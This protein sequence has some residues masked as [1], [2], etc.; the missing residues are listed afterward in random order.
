[1]TG[2][3][4]ET[5]G[6]DRRRALGSPSAR[7][8]L[9]TIFGNNVLPRGEVWTGTVVGVLAT[10]GIEEK[11]ARQALA[12][13]A[14]D[15]WLASTR[16]GRRVRWSFTA[17][18]RELFTRGA[19]RIFSFG[20]EAPSWDG[21]WLV[22]FTSVP[23]TRRELRHRLRTRLAWAGFGSPAPGVWLSPDPN[24]EVEAKEVLAELGLDDT[25]S[26]FVAQYGTIGEPRQLVTAAWD[27]AG[28]E[29]SYEAFRAQ[30]AGAQ[31][32]RDE[33]TFVAHTR[34]VD[35]WRRFPFLDPGLPSGLLPPG[36]AGTRAAELFHT[37][38]AAWRDRAQRFFDAVAA[39][40]GDER[41]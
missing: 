4:L 12:R 21:S 3:R 14:A 19:E 18:G 40:H 34:L 6:P 41:R 31:P 22:L 33:A 2:R 13:T 8:L 23:E 10:L 29:A 35:H 38:H 7:S 39:A 5:S 27:I 1:M 36:W 16:I 20:A 9:M 32:R 25:A 37:R 17:A 26:S 15:G 28:L 24:R 30:F 11:T